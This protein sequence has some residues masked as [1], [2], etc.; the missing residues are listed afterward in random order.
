M[1]GNGPDPTLTVNGGNPCGDCFFA[2]IEHVDEIT[3]KLDNVTY[4]PNGSNVVVIDYFTYQAVKAGVTWRPPEVGAWV[5]ADIQA[6]AQLDTGVDLGDG[7]LYLFQQNLIDGF[8]A[9]NSSAEI[10]AWLSLGQAVIGGWTITDQTDQDF[11]ACTVADVG[12]E[13]QPDSSEG[14]CMPLVYVESPAGICKTNT[15][16]GVLTITNAYRQACL[17]QA[18]GVFTNSQAKALN[19]P[20]YQILADLRAAGGEVQA[21]TPQFPQPATASS[22]ASSRISELEARFDRLKVEFEEETR[23]EVQRLVDGAKCLGI[24]IE[25]WTGEAT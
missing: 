11:E 10:D 5:E 13:N 23:K 7:L 16:G 8:V 12:P 4:V 22:G 18:F 1:L 17:Q 2:A 6:A 21:A 3:S 20:V 15:W 14:H 9:L 25:E 19:L 24:D